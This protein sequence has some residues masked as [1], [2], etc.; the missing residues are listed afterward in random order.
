MTEAEE[1]A[2]INKLNRLSEKNLAK[3]IVYLKELL[4]DETESGG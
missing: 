4:S 2:L 1:Q 3:Y